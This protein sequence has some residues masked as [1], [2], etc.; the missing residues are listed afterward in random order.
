MEDPG[1][2]HAALLAAAKRQVKS[3]DVTTH[4]AEL[5]CLEKQGHIPSEKDLSNCAHLCNSLA[6]N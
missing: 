4:L 5:A 1:H 3:D 2:S 6:R